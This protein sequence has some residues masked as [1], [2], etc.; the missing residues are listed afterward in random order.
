M[1][2]NSSTANAATSE[3][4]T[5]A[6][7][8]SEEQIRWYVNDTHVHTVNPLNIWAYTLAGEDVVVDQAGPLNQ[9]MQITLQLEADGAELPAELLVDYV[10]VWNCDPTVAP[11]IDECASNAVSRINRAA[12]DRVESV[13]AITTDLYTDSLEEL[14]WHYTDEVTELAIA[15][16]NDPVVEELEIGGEHGVV[17]DVSHPAGD[18]NVSLTAPGVELVGRDAVLNFDMYIDSAATD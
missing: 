13:G 2:F 15:T 18:A 7:E 14:S 9:D 1:Q 5:F 17:I 12:S 3:F 10:K 16:W 8:W 11:D 4:Q 6:V